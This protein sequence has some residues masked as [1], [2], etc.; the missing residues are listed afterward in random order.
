[1]PEIQGVPC[2]GQNTGECIGLGEEQQPPPP[3]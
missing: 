1:L 2:T 3:N